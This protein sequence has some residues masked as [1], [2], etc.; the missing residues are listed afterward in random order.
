M[1]TY[2]TREIVTRRKEWVVPAPWP[3]GAHYEEVQKALAA[4]FRARGKGDG[5]VWVHAAD[6]EI[7]ISFDREEDRHV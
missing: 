3:Q 4:A 5:D 1:A 7:V 2:E 6:N